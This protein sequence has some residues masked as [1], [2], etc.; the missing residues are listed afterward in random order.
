[1]RWQRRL[2]TKMETDPTTKSEVATTTQGE[3]AL[4]Q[5]PIVRWWRVTTCR[6]E[7]AHDLRNVFRARNVF[8]SAGQTRYRTYE[9]EA[10]DTDECRRLF[11]E[12]QAHG[13]EDVRGFEI[14]EIEEIPAP[15]KD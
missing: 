5:P 13:I 6:N 8:E 11:A 7:P 10:A 4:V 3:S 14:C 15:N 1:M 2:R 12:A 9:F